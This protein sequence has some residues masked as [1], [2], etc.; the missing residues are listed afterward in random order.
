ML[1]GVVK[2]SIFK[3]VFESNIWFFE[4]K[5]TVEDLIE[6]INYSTIKHFFLLQSY[7]LFFQS[8]LLSDV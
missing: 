1:A 2:C 6:G 4:S 8:V 7:V 5:S 3:F